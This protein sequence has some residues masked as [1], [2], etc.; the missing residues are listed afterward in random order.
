MA[1]TRSKH[2]DEETEPKGAVAMRRSA[3]LKEILGMSSQNYRSHKVDVELTTKKAMPNAC[4]Q[5]C[6]HPLQTVLSA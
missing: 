4:S 6:S 1:A 2:Q 5:S 3:M